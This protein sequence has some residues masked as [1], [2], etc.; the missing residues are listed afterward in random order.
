MQEGNRHYLPACIDCL[1]AYACLYSRWH[2]FKDI[3]KIQ[4]I[5]DRQ[6]T[7]RVIHGWN[8]DGKNRKVYQDFSSYFSF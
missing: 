3:E 2:M 4:S 8:L 6:K 1:T 5:E 7:L